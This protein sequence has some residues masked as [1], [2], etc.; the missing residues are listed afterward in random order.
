MKSVAK[1]YC[2]V[3]TTGNASE[4]HPLTRDVR[5]NAMRALAHLAKFNGCYEQWQ[6]IVKAN[7]LKRKQA[8]D[9]FN[10]FEKE[11]ITEMLDYV[12]RIIGQYPGE[13]ANAFIVATLTGLRADEACQAIRLIKKG[14]KATITRNMVSWNT[15]DSRTFSFGE[16]RRRS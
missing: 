11:D 6:K 15:L 10:F 9:N 5:R 3:L 8:D 7:G 13:C 2:D 14:Q 4:L 16:A 1:K 12:K